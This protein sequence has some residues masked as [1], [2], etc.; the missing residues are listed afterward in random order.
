MS[1]KKSTT[2]CCAGKA[3]SHDQYAT[4][5][6]KQ[7]AR[8]LKG[9]LDLH[10]M[11]DTAAREKVR[12]AVARLEAIDVISEMCVTEALKAELAIKRAKLSKIEKILLA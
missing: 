5:S 1:S 4:C 7:L 3:G 10:Q 2:G 9:E 6:N 12:E 8:M 11:N